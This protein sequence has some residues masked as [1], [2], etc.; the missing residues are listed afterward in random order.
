MAARRRGDEARAGQ[1][2]Q[3]D[4]GLLVL[5]PATAPA[6]LDDLKPPEGTVRM[7]VNTHC[8]QRE[9]H[10]AARRPSPKAHTSAARLPVTRVEAVQSPN[11]QRVERRLAAIF[12]ADVAGYSRLMSQD[13]AG[14]LRALATAREV[15]DGLISVSWWQDRQHGWG[16]R[17][18]GVPERSGCRPVCG[19][20]AGEAAMKRLLALFA[21]AFVAISAS[22]PPAQLLRRLP[23]G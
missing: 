12:A 15:M 6:R 21:I 17:A 11:E 3:H 1:A 2:L 10:R 16:Q 8:S 19:G 4:P 23:L 20:G 18:C 7:T 22:Q 14:T 13:E 9:E 5:R